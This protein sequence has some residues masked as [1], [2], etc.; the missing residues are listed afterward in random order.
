MTTYTHTTFLQAKDRLAQLLGDPNKVF[1]TDREL[2][3]Y[4]VEALRW[5]GLE[6]MYWKESG[7]LV[8]NSGQAFYDIR[9]ITNLAGTEF[10]QS[11]TVT[12]HDLINEMNYSLIENQIVFWPGGWNGSEMFELDEISAELANSRD[13]ILRQSGVVCDEVEYTVNPSVARV[14][15][16]DKT[17]HILRCSIE[18]V[19]SSS[20][21]PL[22]LWAID[23]W[24]AQGYMDTA[25]V[26]P[27]GRPKAFMTNY[28]PTLAVDLFPDPQVDATLRVYSIQAGEFFDPTVTSTIMALP[29]DITWMTKYKTM[30]DLLSGD[31]LSKAPQESQYCEQRVLDALDS[32]ATY[33]SLLWSTLDGRRMTISPLSLLDAQRPNWQSTSGRPRSIHQLNWNTFAVY[34]VPDDD[35]I[36]EVEMVRKAIIPIAD[37]DFIQVGREQIQ[38]I[39]DYAQHI[40]CFKMQGEEFQATM[41]LYQQAKMSAM[42]HQT[43]QAGSSINYRQQLMQAHSDRLM[44]PYRRRELVEESKEVV[45]TSNLQ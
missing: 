39:Y 13:D 3:I 34:P 36:I 4:I 10:L 43:A 9:D 22:P 30:A 45:K 42:E 24:Q 8:L 7:K 1:W 21:Q 35:Y 38:A 37:D 17:I 14:D 23:F 19:S 20:T 18:E 6:A 28:T 11:F 33:Q 12:D 32:L 2:G 31:G 41:P 44:R 27:T 40:A 16:N 29:D 25:G 15:L 5:W 26:F